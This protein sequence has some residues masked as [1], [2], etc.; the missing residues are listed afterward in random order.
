MSGL[1]LAGMISG[2]GQAMGQGLVN[3][4]QGFIQS[5][6]LKERDE[7]ENK[8]MLLTFE[9]AEKL[10]GQKI[11]A[12]QSMQGNALQNA[13]DINAE[14][15]RTHV[16]TTGMSN[17]TSKEINKS[18]ND[19]NAA[20]HKDLNALNEKIAM[21]KDA[22]E[23]ANTD[24]SLDI[25]KNSSYVKMIETAEKSIDRIRVDQV[26]LEKAAALAAPGD[27][28]FDRIK[29]MDRQLGIA[30]K[31]V[32]LY[33]GALG[34][35]LGAPTVPEIPKLKIP[36]ELMRSSSGASAP[37][38][39]AQSEPAGDSSTP[40]ADFQLRRKPTSLVDAVTGTY[41]PFLGAVANA[42][43][44]ASQAGKDEASK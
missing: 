15:N 32:D 34:A 6:L 5:G 28:I 30:Q 3:M 2:A 39:P 26:V 10:Q 37:P 42:V 40:L 36:A 43:R 4:Q 21:I 38:A 12:E 14:T 11:A 35:R 18:T 7:M 44:R 20:I 27:P 29:E 31:E 25:S 33:K 22:R 16:L 41:T 1:A 23:K 8:R 9:H 24:A 13:K 17:D 19:A